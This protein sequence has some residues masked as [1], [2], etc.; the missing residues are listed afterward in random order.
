MV[1]GR[2]LCLDLLFN[3]HAQGYLGQP[4]EQASACQARQPI[5]DPIKPVHKQYMRAR[6]RVCV[7]GA[8]FVCGELGVF[9]CCFHAQIQ[10]FDVCVCVCVWFGCS[11]LLESVQG[12]SL[13]FTCPLVPPCPLVHLFPFVH[14]STCSPFP[15]SP[16]H[17]VAGP[18]LIEDRAKC[19]RELVLVLVH[20]GGVLWNIQQPHSGA[21]QKASGQATRQAGRKTCLGQNAPR[22][23]RQT[24]QITDS[25]STRRSKRKRRESGE[26]AR[27]NGSRSKSPNTS[28]HAYTKQNNKKTKKLN[29]AAATARKKI[30]GCAVRVREGRADELRAR[31]CVCVWV[32]CCAPTNGFVPLACLLACCLFL[33]CCCFVCRKNKGTFGVA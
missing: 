22:S 1:F 16:P 15:L 13:L 9:V 3:E 2:V 8:L 12:L 4:L 11:G 14:L 6:A 20:G 7:C 17:P 31:V 19:G 10:P 26:R 29:A 25:K 5:F 30:K 21:T 33:F 27:A 24:Q 32:C 28:P 23:Y 18:V